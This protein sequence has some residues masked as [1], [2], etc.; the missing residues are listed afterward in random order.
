MA[1]MATI[2]QAAM[3]KY[4][5]IKPLISKHLCNDMSLVQFVHPMIISIMIF[6]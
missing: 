2:V 5:T 6:M 3:L 1:A 4:M